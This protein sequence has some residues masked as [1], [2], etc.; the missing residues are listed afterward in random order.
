MVHLKIRVDVW[1]ALSAARFVGAVVAN[2]DGHRYLLAIH[3]LLYHFKSELWTTKEKNKK[4]AVCQIN[5][6]RTVGGRDT[7]T[8]HSLPLPLSSAHRLRLCCFLEAI[9]S[10]KATR[11][12]REGPRPVLVPSPKNIH[13]QK[14]FECA[15]ILETSLTHHAHT[16]NSCAGQRKTGHRRTCVATSP[17]RFSMLLC[18]NASPRI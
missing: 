6:G 11:F 7:H 18:R 9:R 2:I 15:I 4:R 17:L 3:Q 1:H 13:L 10:E 14:M 16:G 12:L 5:A 8:L